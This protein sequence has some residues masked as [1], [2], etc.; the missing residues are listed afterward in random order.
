MS[1]DQTCCLQD[2][3]IRLGE[4]SKGTSEIGIEIPGF[5]SFF[6]QNCQPAHCLGVNVRVVFPD[7][8]SVS[9]YSASVWD[10]V[11]SF[12]DS[13]VLGFKVICYFGFATSSLL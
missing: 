12:G 10:T 3:G 4:E 13:L 5:D 1:P 2:L 8:F 11:H 7:P 9:H 6:V